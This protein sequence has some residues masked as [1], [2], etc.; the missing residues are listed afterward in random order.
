[1]S[2]PGTFLVGVGVDAPGVSPRVWPTAGLVPRGASLEAGS[3]VGIRRTISAESASNAQVVINFQPIEGN[4]P[5]AFPAG[6]VFNLQDFGVQLQTSA[7]GGRQSYY[8]VLWGTGS[9][10]R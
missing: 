10:V 9:Q 7:L 4:L 5:Q 1:M 3:I 8:D 6:V 2:N